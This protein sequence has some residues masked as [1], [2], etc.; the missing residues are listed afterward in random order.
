MT[1][2]TYLINS[3]QDDGSTVLVETSSENWHQIV[4][5]NKIKPKS[6]RRYFFADIICEGE[7][8]DCIVMEVTKEQFNEWSNQERT[9]RRSRKEKKQYQHFPLDILLNDFRLC[10]ALSTSIEA[11]VLGGV[12]IEEL[13]AALSAWQPWAVDILNLYLADQKES[14]LQ[15]LMSKYG[16]AEITARRYKRDFKYFVKKFLEK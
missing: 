6:D 1:K 10:V 4:A 11:T 14:I 15:Y 13:R 2:T 7:G 12:V 16:I 3:I 5:Q 9:T 8:F